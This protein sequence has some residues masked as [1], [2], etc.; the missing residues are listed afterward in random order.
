MCFAGAFACG[1]PHIADLTERRQE[2]L[3]GSHALDR[4]LSRLEQG[5]RTLAETE[6]LGNDVLVTLQKQR[7]LLKGAQ[8]VHPPAWV[9][10]A[11]VV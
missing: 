1:V 3:Q 9:P 7:Q 2:L 5:H 4:G 8:C 6:A 11:R 10:E